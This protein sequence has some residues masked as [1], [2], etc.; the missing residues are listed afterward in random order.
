MTRIIIRNLLA[1]A[2]LLGTPLTPVVAQAPAIEAEEAVTMKTDYIKVDQDITLRR[3]VVSSGEP[4]GTVLL[5]HGFPETLHVWDD[6][7]ADLGRDYEVHAF[8][9]PGYGQSSRPSADRFSYAPADYARILAGYIQ[10]ARIDRSKLTIYA[11]DIGALPA[12][13]AALDQPDI[14]RSIIVGDFAPFNRPEHMHER[15][16][17]LKSEPSASLAR[18]ELNANSADVLANAFTRG[19]PVEKQFAVSQALKDDMAR[20]WD[21]G[22]LTSA[23]AFFHYYAH[24][25]R[26][27]D[28]FEANIERLSTPVT[29]VWG[30]EDFYIKPAMGAELA[31]KLGTELR[32]LPGVGHYAHLQAPG[33]VIAEIRASF[34]QREKVQ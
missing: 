21:H 3:M 4:K 11:T 22:D 28:F 6:L 5:L 15:I 27:Q 16:Q 26:D 10:Q 19:L 29:V 30:G 34:A 18:A 9:W 23:D 25:T 32:L 7:A 20:G 13:L 1:T 12:L 8:D 31:E 33:Q 24:F 14:A 17:R 2:L